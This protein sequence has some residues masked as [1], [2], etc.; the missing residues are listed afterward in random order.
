MTTFVAVFLFGC[1]QSVDQG[2][3]LDNTPSQNSL[4]E[5]S[6]EEQDTE[7]PDAHQE[8]SE[9][10]SAS[11]VSDALSELHVHFMDVG[12]ADATLFQYADNG[13]D[14]TIL[15]D[16]GDWNK[17]DVVHYL[18][19]ENIDTIDLIIIS[20]PHADH[21]GQLDQI[22]TQFEV[23][24]VWMSGN[25]TSSSTFQHALE[26]VLASDANY[27]EP[28]SGDTFDIGSLEIEVL[29]PEKLTGKLNEDSISARMTY[30]DIS[31]LFTGDALQNE[32]LE[33]L[34]RANDFKA[35]IL[36]LGHHGS[37]TSSHPRFLEAVNPDI[38][39]YSASEDNQYGHP[40]EEV[41]SRI[42][43]MG[44]TLYGTD[45]NGT[46]TVKTDGIEYTVLTKEDGTISTKNKESHSEK[47][48]QPHS[49]HEVATHN[50][51]VDIN[52]ANLEALQQIIHIGPS[53]AEDIISMRPFK[54]VDGLL[55]INGI[56]KSRMS[57]IKTEG[58]ACVGG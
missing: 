8:A 44:I 33:M 53:R 13:E 9:E 35:H 47:P 51:C 25:T 28:Q 42:Q 29:H 50:N 54:S 37:N 58:L 31:F 6:T 30:G 16:A 7:E 27:Y 55:S 22:M 52:Q 38:A 23:D 40:H 39:I 56:G 4:N 57:D 41:I 19:S 24:E 36:Q 1:G 14:Y 5:A 2:N 48:E 20:H 12:Q 26:S 18:S 49:R 11:N 17:S 15:F 10:E 46:I 3:A 21:I 32:E 43:N 34:N 45:V